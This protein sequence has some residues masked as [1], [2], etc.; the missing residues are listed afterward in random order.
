MSRIAVLTGDLI[1]STKVRDPQ[2]FREQLKNMMKL[3]AR[4]YKANTSV[5]R[6]DG[7]QV[8]LNADRYNALEL[9][10][11]LR[12]GLIAQSPDK[13]NRWDARIAIAFGNKGSAGN[14]TL[15]D[16]N[17]EAFINSG[18]TLDD[19]KKEHFLIYAN[20]ETA[21]L[22]AGVATGFADD[23]IN[24]L[25]ATEA[26]VLNL[27]LLHRKSHSDMARQL[28]KKQPTITLALQRARYTLM[29]RYVQDMDKFLARC[30]D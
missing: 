6:G 28:G 30:D 19:M 16:Q 22:A 21:R 17:S 7:F 29:D 12:T 15:E 27:Y 1:K 24:H 20:S 25:T 18:R 14:I 9:A 8:V 3:A 13:K 2:G 10:V 26:E 23:V 4:E 11:V 5:Y